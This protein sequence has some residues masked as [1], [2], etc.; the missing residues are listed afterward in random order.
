MRSENKVDFYFSGNIIMCVVIDLRLCIVL[1]AGLS[2]EKTVQVTRGC[3][4]IKIVWREKVVY[5]IIDIS[6]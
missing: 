1:I 4:R 2:I 5:T 6:L 3:H